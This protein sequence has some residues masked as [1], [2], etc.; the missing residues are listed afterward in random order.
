M[1]DGFEN[2]GT[3][4]RLAN[5][6]F[7]GVE[8]QPGTREKSH[9][10]GNRKLG[11]FEDLSGFIILHHSYHDIPFFVSFVDIPVS[12]NNLYQRIALID[13]RF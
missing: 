2:R 7:H 12:L 5:Y 1:R 3:Y 9:S 6:K 13:D 8:L 11:Y 10:E 4:R